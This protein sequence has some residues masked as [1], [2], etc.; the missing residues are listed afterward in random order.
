MFSS[1]QPTASTVRKHTSRG[2]LSRGVL[3]LT[4]LACA[5]IHDDVVYVFQHGR[6]KSAK[7]YTYLKGNF[8]ERSQCYMDPRTLLVELARGLLASTKKN[9]GDYLNFSMKIK[10][11][12][13]ITMQ[14][15]D[16]NV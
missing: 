6:N 11:Q 7:V 15:P 5:S 13:R 3:T 10:N 4:Y 16:I 2:G 14:F 12:A 1:Q 9:L 8:G